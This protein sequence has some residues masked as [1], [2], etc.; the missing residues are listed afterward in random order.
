M[1]DSDVESAAKVYTDVRTKLEEAME[2][3]GTDGPIM[4][5]LIS[6]VKDLR[7]EGLL[8]MKQIEEKLG[9]FMD[10][11]DRSKLLKEQ[12]V[13]KN[14]FGEEDSVRLLEVVNSE[15]A[16]PR[17]YNPNLERALTTKGVDAALDVIISS[18]KDASLSIVAGWFKNNKAIRPFLDMLIS[19]ERGEYRPNGPKGKIGFSEH[20]LGDEATVL[21]E[22]GHAASFRI[23]SVIEAVFKGNRDPALMREFNTMNPKQKDAAGNIMELY[24][25]VKNQNPELSVNHF[26]AMS[27]VHEFFS[28][29]LTDPAFRRAL[30]N[31]QGIGIFK[32]STAMK[33][34]FKEFAKL[35]GFDGNAKMTSAMAE[36]FV[37]GK[38]LIKY[39]EGKGLTVKEMEGWKTSTSMAEKIGK[40]VKQSQIEKNIEISD[41]FVKQRLESGEADSPKQTFLQNWFGRQQYEGML[42]KG[43]TIVKAALQSIRKADQLSQEFE[44]FVLL[45]AQSVEARWRFG[46]VFNME[47]I[48]NGESIPHHVNNSPLSDWKAVMHKMHFASENRVK[49]SVMIKEHIKGLSE[50]QQKLYKA[51]AAAMDR[52]HSFENGLLS[53]YQGIKKQIPYADGYHANVRKGDYDVIMAYR[54]LTTYAERV[55][56]KA[57]MEHLVAK[58]KSD[59]NFSKMD[60]KGYDIAAEKAKEARLPELAEA[61]REQARWNLE[62]KKST[63]A[64]YQKV[65]DE[66]TRQAALPEGLGGHGKYRSNVPGYEGKKLFKEENI[67]AEEFRQSFVDYPKEMSTLIRNNIINHEMKLVLMDDRLKNRFPNQVETAQHLVDMSTNN[68]QTWTDKMDRPIRNLVDNVIIKAVHGM[69]GK[70]WFPKSHMLDQIHGKAAHLFYMSALTSRPGFWLAQALTS[71]Q[72]IRLMFRTN[73]TS[74]AFLHTGKGMMNVMTGGDKS[75]QEAVHWVASNMHTFHPQFINELNA[76]GFKFTDRIGNGGL[77]KALRNVLPWATGEKQAGVMDAFSRYAS[78]AMFYEKYKGMGLTKEALYK[79]AAKDTDATM[80]MYNAANKSPFIRKL[81]VFGDAVAPLQTFATGQLGNLVADA[82]FWMQNPADLR[83]ALPL[84][85][86]G[87]TTTMFAGAIGLPFIVEYEALRQLAIFAGVEP[88]SIPSIIDMLNREETMEKKEIAGMTL[89]RG[90]L[91]YG[92][93]TASTGFDIGSGMR[94]N[95]IISKVILEEKNMTTLFPAVEYGRQLAGALVTSLKAE[96]PDDMVRQAEHR[97]AL[98]MLGSHVIGGKAFVDETQFNAGGREFVPGGARGYAMREQTGQE[99]FSTLLGSGTIEAK[100]SNNVETT[101]RASEDYRSKQRQKMIDIVLDGALAGDGERVQRAVDKLLSMGVDPK[102]INNQLE[103]AAGNRNLTQRQRF[104]INSKGKVTSKEAQRRYQLQSI[105]GDS[106]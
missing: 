42:G 22:L 73:S 67:M 91:T 55:R 11:L 46:M 85:I 16:N 7:V 76:I 48:K 71:T 75:F 58:L 105:Y 45:G 4:E 84:V 18:P 102:S 6:G 1:L 95:Q 89:P 14:T 8:R 80:I 15:T 43:H 33:Q 13:L 2:I 19:K 34:L 23:F 25:A 51:L 88:D 68:F 62:N 26:E 41:D 36:L 63:P 69:G 5:R 53:K 86:T 106:F 81:G 93:I 96:F 72:A 57:E 61:A 97:K 100:H 40:A 64:E 94:W 77:S 65:I 99:R 83:K 37:H 47:S 39:S 60:V 54:G 70:E 103:S 31:E 104:F 79:A 35:L 66:I 24:A 30:M 20:G 74:E 98:M 3:A 27:N 50:N 21:H 78:F 52:A 12:Q 44:N 38:T 87:M 56:T 49:H 92:L 29:G 10:E 28:Y 59:P 90:A 82:K 17:Y 9:S 101:L 32:F